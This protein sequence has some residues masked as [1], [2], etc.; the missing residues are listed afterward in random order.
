MTVEPY[1]N[2]SEACSLVDL[3]IRH[4]Y[5]PAMY[6]VISVVGFMGNLMAIVVYAVKLRP[7]QSGSVIMVNLATADLLYALSLPFLVYFYITG[8]WTLGEFTCRFTR[9]C[10][11]FNLYGSVLFLAC[12]AAFRY[13]AVAHPLRAARV[14]R[15]RRGVWACLA[16][17]AVSLAEITPMLSV[18][19]TRREG[20]RT[21][22]LDFASN[23][24]EQV[25]WYGWLLTALGF[26]LPLGVVCWCYLRIGA[27]LG[28]SLSARQ[29]SRVRAHR[30]TVV[31]L[32]V[33]V[34]C[35]LPYHV[36]R[37]LRV[38]SL[39]G[40]TMSCGLKRTINTAY[41]LSRPLA[42]LNAFFN[43]PLYTL[44]GDKF[45]QAFSSLVWQK[46][47]ISRRTDVVPAICSLPKT[48]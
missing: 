40:N 12:I 17:W 23:E 10:F 20:N 4:R 1:R 16:V 26:L 5:L 14:R 35:F 15:R 18:I 2:T 19:T 32:V 3:H 22:C 13:A 31:V 24:P 9:F 41:M 47:S 46:R 27:T 45:Q 7:W 38:A 34:G 29:P 30:L 44:A 25:W 42:G 37:A 28:H 33:F 36:L 43:M 39:R 8:D 48:R 21:L 11:H 6:G